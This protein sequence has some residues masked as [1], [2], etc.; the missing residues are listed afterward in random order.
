MNVVRGRF[1]ASSPR[2]HCSVIAVHHVFVKSIL[3]VSPRRRAIEA[4]HVGLV[5]AEQ[6]LML[7]LRVE[8]V[9][10]ERSMLR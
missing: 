9:C 6:Q 5:L 8:M 1:G 2:V 4:L 7:G 10:A 3:E